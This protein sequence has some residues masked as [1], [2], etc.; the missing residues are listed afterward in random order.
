MV[1]GFDTVPV[2]ERKI[3]E[4]CVKSSLDIMLLALFKRAEMSGYSALS[5]IHQSFNVLLSPGT[6]YS[7]LTKLEREGLIKGRQDE[8]KRIYSL[9]PK[10]MEVLSRYIAE[11]ES[12]QSKIKLL[13]ADYPKVKG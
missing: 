5:C 6:L 13:F 4:R 9:T 8:R 10:G 1:F 7:T 11:Y 2:M 12:F 3:R